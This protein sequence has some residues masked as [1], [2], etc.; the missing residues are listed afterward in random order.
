MIKRVLFLF[1]QQADGIST[2]ASMRFNF[3]ANLFFDVDTCGDKL[4]QKD[5]DSRR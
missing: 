5:N 2:G 3:A 1:S 4:Q